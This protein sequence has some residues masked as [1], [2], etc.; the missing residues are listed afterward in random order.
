MILPLA[1]CLALLQQSPVAPGQAPMRKAVIEGIIVHAATGEPLRKAQVSLNRINNTG[2]AVA[3]ITDASGRFT[4]PAVEPGQYR[5]AAERNGFV[6]QEHGAKRPGRAG[7]T[8]A[9]SPGEILR[10]VKIA[11]TPQS[12]IAGRVFDEDGEPLASISVQA[13]RQGFSR[14]RREWFPVNGATTNDLGEYRIHGLAPGRYF[15]TATARLGRVHSDEAYPIVYHPGSLDPSGAVPVELNAGAVYSGIDFSLRRVATGQIRGRII[16]SPSRRMAVMLLPAAGSA[17]RYANADRAAAIDNDGR[18]EIRGVLPGSYIL[19]ARANESGRMQSAAQPVQV[20]AGSITEANLALGPGIEIKGAVKIE[21]QSAPPPRVYITMTPGEGPGLGMQNTRSQDDGRFAANNL[22]ATDYR[23]N[24]TNLPAGS[25][26][27]SVKMGDLD[28]LANGLDLS[29]G[30]AG[31]SVEILI[32]PSA[33]QVQ[34]VAMDADGKPSIGATIVLV[35]GESLRTRP[36]LYRTA[37]TDHLGRFSL[38]GLAPGDYKLFAWEDVEFGF[39]LDADFMRAQESHG[40]S[41]TLAEK[42]Q[43]NLQLKVIPAS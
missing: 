17:V 3:V 32:S 31:D 16:G 39:W 40:Q 26:L 20:A 12:V 9:L 43:Q 10:D 34:G 8:V 23:L 13:L 19:S 33:A 4:F 7:A 15:L 37:T 2:S 6:R 22:V 25:Y 5:I 28:V 27:K 18:Y 21:G 1:L 11:L 35:P 24:V 14:G 30:A 42:D 29:R 38:T 41:L 36:Y